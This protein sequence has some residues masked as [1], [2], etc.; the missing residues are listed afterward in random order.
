MS[1]EHGAFAF[2]SLNITSASFLKILSNIMAESA[3]VTKLAFSG[4][5]LGIEGSTVAK[6]K[7]IVKFAKIALCV[8]AL[9]LLFFLALAWLSIAILSISFGS[10]A[11]LSCVIVVHSIVGRI[12]LS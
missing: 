8:L 12:F 6:T 9:L 11:C 4:R 2:E 7:G 5:K 3:S 10:T 1:L